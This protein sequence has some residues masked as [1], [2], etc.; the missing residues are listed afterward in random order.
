[1]LGVRARDVVEASTISDFAFLHISHP[2]SYAFLIDWLVGAKEV[3]VHNILEA[4]TISLIPHHST[5]PHPVVLVGCV[6]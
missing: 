1:V 3:W 2:H 4:S 6:D 5:S